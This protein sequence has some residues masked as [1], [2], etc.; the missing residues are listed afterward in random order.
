[1]VQSQVNPS[2]KHSGLVKRLEKTIAKEL[3]DEDPMVLTKTEMLDV[4]IFTQKVM[5]DF[6]EYIDRNY[7][8]NE[9]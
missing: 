2:H 7:T 8:R 3:Y 1:M 9:E 6:N 5:L 4:R